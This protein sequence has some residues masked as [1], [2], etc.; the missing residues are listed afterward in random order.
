MARLTKFQKE[1]YGEDVQYILRAI[2][3]NS[4][5]SDILYRKEGVDSSGNRILNDYQ[6]IAETKLAPDTTSWVREIFLRLDGLVSYVKDVSDSEGVWHLYNG[7]YHKAVTSEQV[8]Q[9]IQECSYQYNY[10]IDD[11]VRIWN[12]SVEMQIKRDSE[13][14]DID[15]KAKLARNRRKQA[16]EEFKLLFNEHMKVDSELRT[17]SRAKRLSDDLKHYVHRTPKEMK[18]HDKDYLVFK[19]YAFNARKFIDVART[20]SDSQ[21]NNL[22]L[23]CLEKPSPDIL[24]MRGIDWEIK[25]TDLIHHGSTLDSS[26]D[27]VI[28]PNFMKFLESSVCKDPKRI[29]REHREVVD[30][31]ELLL[32]GFGVAIIGAPLT[33]RAWFGIQGTQ[34]SGKSVLQNLLM[35]DMFPSYCTSIQRMAFMYGTN[36]KD[37]SFA[38]HNLKDMRLGFSDEIEGRLREDIIKQFSG[39]S[40]MSTEEKRKQAVSWE[41]QGILVLTSNKFYNFDYSDGAMLER[42]KP[43]IMNKSYN[44]S[45][46]K[47]LNLGMKLFNERKDI[48]RVLLRACL[49]AVRDMEARGTDR[50]TTISLDKRS[51]ILVDTPWVAEHKKSLV[52][53]KDYEYFMREAFQNNALEP[54]YKV[55]EFT[56]LAS[57]N[58]YYKMWKDKNRLEPPKRNELQNYLREKGLISS[59]RGRYVL[60]DFTINTVKMSDICTGEFVDG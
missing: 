42:F 27:K 31:I 35:E 20:I 6:I 46:D 36:D 59:V 56:T 40:S 48:F 47:D 28:A 25:N 58:K 60:N 34:S 18:K 13:G 12:E 29:G 43:I 14:M 1:S 32:Q 30:M 22:F 44:N 52:V 45:K 24:V 16:K 41:P 49:R 55:S 54:C 26:N 5:S 50:E 9:I 39:G 17:S 7:Q 3:V 10:V 15:D 38:L 11:L 2:D 33:A 21:V 57:L 37:A 23:E 51:W 19:D 4:W 8:V 53:D